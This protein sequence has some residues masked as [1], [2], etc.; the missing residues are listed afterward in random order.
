[1]LIVGA[2]AHG[3]MILPFGVQEDIAKTTVLS[4]WGWTIA[5]QETMGTPIGTGSGHKFIW[6]VSGWL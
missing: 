6:S 3:T 1:M 2:Q 4:D 5:Y